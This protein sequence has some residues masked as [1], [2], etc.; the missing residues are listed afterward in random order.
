MTVTVYSITNCPKCAA[1]RAVLKR[2]NVAFEEIN[3]QES[4][5]KKRE[6]EQKL[7]AAGIK[8]EI[9]MPVVDI[10]G[11]MVVGFDKEKIFTALKEKGLGE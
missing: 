7:Q 2:K 11:T 6:M 4:E 5:V 3:V 8:E 10:A 9:M 1:A